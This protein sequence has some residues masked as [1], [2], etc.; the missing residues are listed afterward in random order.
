MSL[1]DSKFFPVIREYLKI[2]S[3]LREGGGS[4]NPRHRIECYPMPPV[5][6]RQALEFEMPCVACGAP[7][8][9]F[10]QRAGG[11]GHLFYAPTCKLEVNIGCSRGRAA[12]DE[13][14]KVVAATPPPP[15]KRTLF[16]G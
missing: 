1:V 9:P 10:R 2:E 4:R 8:H 16:G 15:K 14:R 11:H 6:L 12:S 5:I 13:Y 3:Y 7:N